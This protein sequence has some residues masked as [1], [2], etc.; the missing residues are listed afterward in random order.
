[1]LKDI[2]TVIGLYPTPVTVYGTAL[3]D[4]CVKWLTIA[5]VGAIE[6]ER[7]LASIDKASGL[8][9]SSIVSNGTVSV[10]LVTRDM[11]EATRLVRHRQIR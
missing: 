6:H 8:S 2:G 7:L 4:G 9:D 1:M 11:V 5:H 10:S 3:E